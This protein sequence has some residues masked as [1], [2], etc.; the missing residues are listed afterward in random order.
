MATT[1]LPVR[2]SSDIVSSTDINTLNTNDGVVKAVGFLIPGDA[3]VEVKTTQLLMPFS[4]TLFN[5]IA[6]ADTAPVGSAIQIDVNKNG[7]SMLTTVCEIDDGDNQDDGNVVIKSDGTE[8]VVQYD[9]ISIDVD[10][11]GS[12]TAG[13]DDLMVTLVFW[14]VT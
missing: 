13:G 4:G 7:T 6:Y 3:S 1:K 14:D 11:I 10:Q 9:R 2:T 12:G 5:V 8:D